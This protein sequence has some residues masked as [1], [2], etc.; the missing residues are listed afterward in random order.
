M[1]AGIF[2]GLFGTVVVGISGKHHFNPIF[3]KHFRLGYFLIGGYDGHEYYSL[4][5]QFFTTISKSLCMV[6]RTR[7][8]HPILYLIIR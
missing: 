1:L 4:D 6:A 8:N 2:Q 3:P 5:L 7:A